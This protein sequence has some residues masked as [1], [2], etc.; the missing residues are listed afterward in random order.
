MQ[1]KSLK[2]GSVW[3]YKKNDGGHFR[4]RHLY[5]PCGWPMRLSVPLL[6]CFCDHSPR[7][8]NEQKQPHN[9]SRLHCESF[10]SDLRWLC[11]LDRPFTSAHTPFAAFGG[12]CRTDYALLRIPGLLGSP[13][14]FAA[15]PRLCVVSS[16][17]QNCPSLPKKILSSLRYCDY[18]IANLFCQLTSKPFYKLP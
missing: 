13:S 11:I 5:F 1:R 14:D 2:C 17:D 9:S 15:K 3:V 6:R 4:D 12:N 7:N 8:L 10:K 16:D 18:I